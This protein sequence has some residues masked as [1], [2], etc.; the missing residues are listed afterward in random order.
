MTEKVYG[1]ADY[2]RQDV[3]VV[4][5]LKPVFGNEHTA[6]IPGLTRNPVHR[7]RL[8]VYR[9]ADQVRHDRKGVRDGGL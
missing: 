7:K 3:I 1:M 4:H 5:F 6:V 2:S 9:M 8:T